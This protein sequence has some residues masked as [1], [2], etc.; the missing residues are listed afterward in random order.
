MTL[1][2]FLSEM[3]FYFILFVKL[4]CGLH[5]PF[6]KAS[7]LTFLCRLSAGALCPQQK[8]PSLALSLKCPLFAICLLK[9]Q[10]G[11]ASALFQNL[12]WVV[13]PKRV[14]NANDFLNQ[15]LLMWDTH[16]TFE[17]L[18]GSQLFQVIMKVLSQCN[19]SGNQMVPNWSPPGYWEYSSC[20]IRGHQR[21]T[22]KSRMQLCH[23][24][25]KS[26]AS[27]GPSRVQFSSCLKDLKQQIIECDCELQF[28]GVVMK[29][30]GE[31]TSSCHCCQWQVINA[32]ATKFNKYCGIYVTVLVGQAACWLWLQDE[33][34]T[35]KAQVVLGH[36][37]LLWRGMIKVLFQTLSC[38]LFV[39]YA[40]CM[41]AASGGEPIASGFG[42]DESSRGQMETVTQIIG[43]IL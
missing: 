42:H 28:G 8:F 12:S 2:W 18:W 6:E 31:T 20:K 33:S 19:V 21:Q 36:L 4:V 26:P 24:S 9:I 38:A 22:F 29:K 35:E 11:T 30:L 10:K 3:K 13:Q 43:Q 39:A 41:C 7:R 27:A 17:S 25:W 23:A 1:S 5:P 34:K 32:A 40:Y 15:V 37:L 16:S 14:V